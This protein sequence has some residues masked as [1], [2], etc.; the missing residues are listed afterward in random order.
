MEFFQG[1]I[2]EKNEQKHHGIFLLGEL[3]MQRKSE[4]FDATLAKRFFNGKVINI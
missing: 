2:N 4:V 1:F 3:F